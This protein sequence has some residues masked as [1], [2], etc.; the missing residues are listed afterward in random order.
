MSAFG[1]GCTSHDPITTHDWKPSHVKRTSPELIDA[2]HK[3]DVLVAEF[4]A[5][6][7]LLH[8]GRLVDFDAYHDLQ[9]RMVQQEKLVLSLKRNL[10]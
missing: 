8:Y 6:S 10:V 9:D 1:V 5:Q 3:L 4:D 7:D 2:M